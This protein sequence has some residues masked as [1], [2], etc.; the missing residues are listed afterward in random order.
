MA[1]VELELFACRER[2]TS[3][4]P[5]PRSAASYSYVVTPGRHGF[6]ASCT[7]LDAR[8]VA[9]TITAAV[10]SMRAAIVALRDWP[11]RL[12]NRWIPRRL[13]KD[14]VTASRNI[15]QDARFSS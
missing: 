8:G 12:R 15:D 3:M 13:S 11:V 6:L 2:S 1:G 5:I 7:E 9:K 10:S 4:A 14:E